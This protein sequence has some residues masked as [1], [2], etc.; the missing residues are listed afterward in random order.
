MSFD[1]RAIKYVD[2]VNDNLLCCI[3]QTPFIDP[4]TTHCGHTFCSHCIQQSLETSCQCPI[5][6]TVIRIEEIKPAV[7]IIANIVNELLVHCPEEGCDFVGQRQFIE[8]HI[9]HDCQYTVTCCELEECKEL[10]LKKDLDSHAENCQFRTLEC[11]MCKKKLKKFEL[12]KHYDHCPAEMIECVYCNSCRPRFEHGQHITECPQYR[13]PCDHQTYG[14]SWQDERQQLVDHLKRCPYEPIKDYLRQQDQK[15]RSLREDILRLQKENQSLKRQ[16]YESQQRTD[17]I[18]ERLGTMFPTYFSP[19][20]DMIPE[21]ARSESVL[22]ENQRVASELETLSA[23]IASLELKQ[24]MALMTETFRLQEELQGLRSVCHGLRM[25]MHYLMMDRKMASTTSAAT[26]ANTTNGNQSE[27]GT[28]PTG[29]MSS[30][31]RMRTLLD[32]STQLHTPPRP[33][34]KL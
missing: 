14:C 24:N 26:T 19:D 31:N 34:T 28:N 4:V 2:K 18:L 17:S 16:Q 13:I 22:A 20:L 6:R 11:Q 33:E 25:Q 8:S 15:E 21:E 30:R 29:T 10:L 23:N 3:C 32:L 7:K 12:Q 5:D 9:K 1:I 27:N